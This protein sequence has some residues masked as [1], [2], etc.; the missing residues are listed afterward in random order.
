MKRVQ[1]TP[2]AEQLLAMT[3]GLKASYIKVAFPKTSGL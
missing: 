3:I 2:Q 1:H